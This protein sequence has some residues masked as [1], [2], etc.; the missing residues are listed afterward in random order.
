[1]VATGK[2]NFLS[3]ARTL[4]VMESGLEGHRRHCLDSLQGTMP[5]NSR[6]VKEAW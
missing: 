6:Y 2:T 1:M 5:L 3:I 4:R